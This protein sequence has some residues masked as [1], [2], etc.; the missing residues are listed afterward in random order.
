MAGGQT[1]VTRTCHVSLPNEQS[2]TQANWWNCS[3]IPGPVISNVPP[4]NCL[5][6]LRSALNR[7]INSKKRKEKE[8]KGKKRKEKERKGKKKHLTS[9]F[10]ASLQPCP[11]TWWL[12]LFPLLNKT[13]RALEYSYIFEVDRQTGTENDY[14]LVDCESEPSE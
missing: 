9:P 10:P 8:R 2:M 6:G 1:G 3:H 7:T 4:V 14:T 11:F 12:Q 13:I 5:T